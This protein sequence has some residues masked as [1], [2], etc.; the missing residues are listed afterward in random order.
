MTSIIR[1]HP[2]MNNNKSGIR[3][4]SERWQVIIS[5]AVIAAIAIWL[6]YYQAET[7][8][9]LAQYDYSRVDIWQQPWRILTAHIFHLDATHALYNA[10][11]FLLISSLFAHHFTVRTWLSALIIIAL[12]CVITVWVI[13]TPERFVGLSGVIHGLL[14]TS[15]LLEWAQ[16]NYQLIDWLPP[17]TI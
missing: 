5:A 6:P 9:L 3:S 15:L 7:G 14:L 2:T 16:K 12:A 11:G 4:M 8:S 10:L 17:L 13:G 1:R